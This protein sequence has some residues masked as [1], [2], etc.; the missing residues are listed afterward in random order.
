[1]IPAD[2]NIYEGSI[3][4]DDYYIYVVCV[5]WNVIVCDNSVITYL[6]IDNGVCTSY[7]IVDAR[8]TAS[9]DSS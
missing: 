2:T 1:M 8:T 9:D 6:R 5:S 7:M 4:I 3:C